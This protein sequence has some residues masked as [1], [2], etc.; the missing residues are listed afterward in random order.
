MSLP[1]NKNS[2]SA[3]EKISE[4]KFIKPNK[5]KPSRKSVSPNPV[6]YNSK[7]QIDLTNNQKISNREDLSTKNAPDQLS[8]NNPFY[9]EQ[10]G[11]K[12]HKEK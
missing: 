11:Y 4:Y 2:P 3:I 8:Q 1:D 9:L 12:R 6:R 10:H 7:M 5:F